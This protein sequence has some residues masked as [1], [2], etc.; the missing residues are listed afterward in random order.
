MKNIKKYKYFGK[1]YKK[2]K[3]KKAPV[4]RT[5]TYPQTL[6]QEKSFGHR[7]NE[8]GDYSLFTPMTLQCLITTE[9]WCPSR[10]E[11][12]SSARSTNVT[13]ENPRACD[14]S[15]ETTGGQDTPTISSPTS[16][17][18][19]NASNF[20]RHSKSSQSSTKTWPPILWKS[21]T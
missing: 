21:L 14:V 12:P 10:A 9:L 5:P 15:V 20:C 7:F 1:Y 4:Q 19:R 3:K 17:N 8:R 18:V 13:P 11:T 2:N 6:H 16:R